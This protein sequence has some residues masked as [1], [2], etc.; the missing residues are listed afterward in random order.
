MDDRGKEKGWMYR[1]RSEIGIEKKILMW[2]DENEEEIDGRKGKRKKLK[3]KIVKEGID[4]EINEK[5]GWNGEV[6]I[7]GWK[8][9]EE[10]IEIVNENDRWGWIWRM[11]EGGVKIKGRL[12]KKWIEKI[13]IERRDEEG[14]KKEIFMMRSK[15]IVDWNGR[16]IEK[17]IIGEIRDFW[18][19]VVNRN[20]KIIMYLKKDKRKEGMKKNKKKL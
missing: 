7:V 19:K 11:N 13:G 8:M 16:K 2:V 6:I 10:I 20:G 14:E 4:D 15:C 18:F 9:K 5:K 1:L 3:I 17:E 12:G